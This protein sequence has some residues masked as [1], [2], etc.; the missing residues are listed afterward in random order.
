L[1]KRQPAI[2]GPSIVV[3]LEYLERHL[4]KANHAADKISRKSKRPE[5]ASTLNEEVF[6]KAVRK[7]FE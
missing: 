6:L 2:V 4:P 3:N 5:F 1:V 7:F